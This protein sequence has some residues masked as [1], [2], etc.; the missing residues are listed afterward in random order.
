MH[1]A[2]CQIIL[3]RSAPIVLPYSNFSEEEKGSRIG[4]PARRNAAGPTLRPAELQKSYCHPNFFEV[5]IVCI[6][7][8]AVI[9]SV[10]VSVVQLIE[11]ENN[12]R[13]SSI[14]PRGA[15]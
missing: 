11:I 10:A 13:V 5:R 8:F 1:S 4:G 9:Q 14:I 6:S 7:R 3:H 2:V 12:D 15:P